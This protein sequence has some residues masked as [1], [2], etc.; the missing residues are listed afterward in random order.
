M[1][2]QKGQRGDKECMTPKQGKC[3]RRAERRLPTERGYWPPD[4]AAGGW[5]ENRCYIGGGGSR[6]VG[7]SGTTATKEGRA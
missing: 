4:R 1:G 5:P 7:I 6:G 3:S 2:E